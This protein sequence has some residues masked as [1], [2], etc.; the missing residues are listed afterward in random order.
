MLNLGGYVRNQMPKNANVICEGSLM[1][2]EIEKKG[3]DTNYF[4]P[5][6]ELFIDFSMASLRYF[7]LLIP[8]SQTGGLLC[9][10]PCKVV[11]HCPKLNMIEEK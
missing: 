8:S 1:W 11:T 3:T 9:S 2:K 4:L 5:K 6:I 7:E 10:G